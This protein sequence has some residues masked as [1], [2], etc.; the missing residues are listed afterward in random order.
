MS[1]D[2]DHSPPVAPLNSAIA[3]IDE[4]NALEE[5]GR[6]LEAMARYEAAAR[7]DPRCARAHLN[8]GNILFASLKAR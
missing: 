1:R 6:I 2:A 4:G 8:R 5:Q 3:L 7:I